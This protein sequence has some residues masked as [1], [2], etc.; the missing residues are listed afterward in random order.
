MGRPSAQ[1]AATARTHPKTL[2]RRVWRACGCARVSGFTLLEVML[3]LVLFAVGTVAAMSLIHQAQMGSR[4]GEFDLIATYR[5]AECLESLRNVTYPTLT[6]GSG[7]MTGTPQCGA[8]VAE[9]PQIAGGNERSVTIVQPFTNLKQ[10]MVTISWAA[11]GSG[12]ADVAL[13]TYRS[14]I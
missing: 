8:D 9:L 10:I 2:G 5:A 3:A 13:Q 1:R 6:V 14:G 4:D 7:V 11:P 12:S